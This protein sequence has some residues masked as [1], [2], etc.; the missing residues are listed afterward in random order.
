M[1]KL[2][3]ALLM[4]STML[5]WPNMIFHYNSFIVTYVKQTLIIASIAVFAFLGQKKIIAF[6]GYL[7]IMLAVCVNYSWVNE[8]YFNAY[9]IRAFYFISACAFFYRY[10]NLIGQYLKIGIF[11]SALLGLQAFILTILMLGDVTISYHN[12]V[13][14]DDGA[15]REFNWFAGF[16]ND[17]DY[18]RVVSYFTETNRLAYFL[19]PSLFVSYYYAKSSLFFKAAF[20][21]ILFGIVS[22]FSAFSFFAIIVGASFYMVYARRKGLQYLLFVPIYVIFVMGIYFLAPEY[23]AT[24]MDKTGSLA[25]RVLGIISKVEMITSNPL[26]IGEVALAEALELTPEANSTLTMLYWGTV[27]GLQSIALLL[28]LLLLWSRSILELSRVK[29]GFL[30]LLACGML[31]SLMQQSFYGTYFEYY[32][33]SMMAALT[34]SD[35][36]YRRSLKSRVVA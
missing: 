16:R 2:V 6:S 22:T 21:F 33:L 10:P 7:A 5:H 11:I 26:G 29:N 14:I 1:R 27:G 34:A 23:F 12:V 30:C 25:Y 3:V 19:T 13:F 31:A 20:L 36:N 15:E 32:F 24:L 35:R 28:L 17:Y 4:V 18:F 8:V 9:F